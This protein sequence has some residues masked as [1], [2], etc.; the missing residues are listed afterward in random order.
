MPLRELYLCGKDILAAAGINHTRLSLLFKLLFV[1]FEVYLFV[2][3]GPTSAG[4]GNTTVPGKGLP[5]TWVLGPTC[6][7]SSIEPPHVVSGNL[8]SVEFHFRQ[9]QW[10]LPSDSSDRL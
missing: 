1:G 5:E 3:D 7:V 4:G 8:P 10:S 2:T 9:Y 6:T